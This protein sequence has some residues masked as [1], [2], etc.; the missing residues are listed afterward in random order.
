VLSVLVP[1]RFENLKNLHFQ[2][3]K[4]Q[5]S[6]SNF[7][8]FLTKTNQIRPQKTHSSKYST[9]GNLTCVFNKKSKTLRPCHS[10]T[11]TETSRLEVIKESFFYD[12]QEKDNYNR[13]ISETGT[14]FS[15]FL[16]R[17]ALSY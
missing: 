3:L 4:F 16:V 1:Y 11:L 6:P 12:H 8:L 7:I 13:D 10:I 15:S 9:N 14:L 17:L 2:L 5:V